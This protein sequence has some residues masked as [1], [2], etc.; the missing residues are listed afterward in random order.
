MSKTSTPQELEIR[1]ENMPKFVELLENLV[2][3]NIDYEKTFEFW[4]KEMCY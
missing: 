3:D 1:E 2:C 4:N